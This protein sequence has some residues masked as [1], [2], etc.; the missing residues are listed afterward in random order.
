MTIP[1][2]IRLRRYT[3]PTSLTLLPRKAT[4]CNQGISSALGL[5]LPVFKDSEHVRRALGAWQKRQ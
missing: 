3:K 2:C 4:Q 1:I 5:S